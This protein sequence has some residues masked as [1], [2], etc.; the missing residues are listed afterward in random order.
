MTAREI[1][2]KASAAMD[3]GLP[4]DPE[5]QSQ[6]LGVMASTYLN[7]GL[8]GRA[9]G[10]A[11]RALEARERLYGLGEPQDPRVDVPARMDIGPGRP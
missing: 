10:L 11:T 8:Y 4:Q 2:D 3:G 5:V 7:L 6:M 9:H 1:L